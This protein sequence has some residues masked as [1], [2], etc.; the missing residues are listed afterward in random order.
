MKKMLSTTLVAIA[1]AMVSTVDAKVMRR[2]GA[3]NTASQ[4]V[5]NIVVAATDLV[6]A[7]AADMPA[8][9]EVQ[10]TLSEQNL[11]EDE[12]E[13]AVLEFQLLDTNN[14]IAF[15]VEQLKDLK[16]GMFGGLFTATKDQKAER[17]R[18]NSII[19]KL[20]ADKIQIESDMAKL[21]P[22]V[23]DKFAKSIKLFAIGVVTTMVGSIAYTV[24]QKYFGGQGYEALSTRAKAAGQYIAESRIGQK[25]AAFKD[26]A[27]KKWYGSE[28]KGK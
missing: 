20:K 16:L 8:M 5:N 24:D 13:Y 17:D 11:T 23:G 19:T 22:V 7:S 25:T 15:R 4:K 3:A 2:T 9:T 10:R 27:M 21:R 28:S 1:F 6:E 12:R 14:R 18:L 26:D